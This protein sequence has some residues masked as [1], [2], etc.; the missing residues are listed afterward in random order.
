M[1]RFFVDFTPENNCIL[2]GENSVHIS[3]SLRMKTGDEVILCDGNAVDFRCKITEITHDSVALDV[4][5]SYPC[6]AEPDISV[7]L[8]QGIPKGDKMESIIQKSV[9]LGVNKIVPLM[10]SRV[11]SRPDDKSMQKK[12]VRWQKISLEAAKQS[13]RGIIPKVGECVDFSALEHILTNFDA[14]LFCY[15]NGGESIRTAYNGAKNIAVIIGSEGGFSPDEAEKLNSW[16]AKTVT[17]GR[18]ILR[19]E[20]APLAVLSVLMYTSGNMDA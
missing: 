11:I 7:T 13:G 6:Q 17:L 15:E 20:T 12:I 2:T 14:V 3:R 9:E 18:R 16:G 4:L 19:T 1:P 10:T 5:E 8:F